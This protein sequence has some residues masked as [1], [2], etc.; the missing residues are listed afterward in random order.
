MESKGTMGSVGSMDELLG[1][2]TLDPVYGA[3]G[4]SSVMLLVV[5]L[6]PRI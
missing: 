2:A 5:C 4:M 6:R 1:L 3:R